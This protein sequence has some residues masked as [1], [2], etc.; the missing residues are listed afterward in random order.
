MFGSDDNYGLMAA[1][2]PQWNAAVP[3]T[4]LIR[5]DGTVAY[6]RQGAGDPIEVRR[7]MLANLPDDDYIGIRAHWSAQ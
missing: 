1:F 3:Y 6:K 2:D 5:P 4:V 7:L